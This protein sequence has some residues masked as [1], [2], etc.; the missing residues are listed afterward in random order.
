MQNHGDDDGNDEDDVRDDK[1][2]WSVRETDPVLRETNPVLRSTSSVL[3]EKRI[4][5][6]TGPVL[7]ETTPRFKRNKPRS[8]RNMPLPK[9]NKLRSERTSSRSESNNPRSDENKPRSDD[10]DAAVPAAAATAADADDFLFIN[11]VMVH[12]QC[13]SA[14]CRGSRCSV[15]LPSSAPVRSWQSPLRP[16]LILLLAAT[17]R[18]RLPRGVMPAMAS[19]VA[20]L[21]LA[22]A[23]CISRERLE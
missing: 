17:I 12:V 14:R 3:R 23:F 15:A 11:N 18:A 22:P 8:N 19:P 5:R 16:P 21:M 7:R 6:E 10:D 4:L 20:V 2:R 9:K 1:K 13:P